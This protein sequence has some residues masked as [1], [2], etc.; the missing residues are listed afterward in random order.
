MQTDLS[1]FMKFQLLGEVTFLLSAS[2]LHQQAYIS[3][4]TGNILPAIELNQFRI[5]RKQDYPVGFVAWAYF[6]DE[7]EQRFITGPMQLQPEDWRSGSNLFFVEFVAPFGHTRQIVQDLTRNIF[8]GRVAKS[9]RFK[10]LGKPPRLC[11]W[12]ARKP[13]IPAE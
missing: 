5:Y 8:P 6:S 13:Q 7:T 3:N 10:E 4:V 9:L 11:R 12:A 1:Q 2:P